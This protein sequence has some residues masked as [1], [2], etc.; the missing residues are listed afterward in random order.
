MVSV[1]IDQPLATR[2]TVGTFHA[3]S[4]SALAGASLR[5]S[6]TSDGALERSKLWPGSKPIFFSCAM[7]GWSVMCGGLAFSSSAA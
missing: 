2:A 5:P 1:F 4:C 6:C 7:I 3:I